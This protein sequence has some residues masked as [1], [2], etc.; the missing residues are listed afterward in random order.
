MPTSGFQPIGKPSRR[1]LDRQRFD[2][3]PLAKSL[4]IIDQKAIDAAR[5]NYCEHCGTMVGPFEVHHHESRGAGG[6]D[7]E[8]NLVNLCS[9]DFRVNCHDLAHRAIIP[10]E[11]I[12][13]I[14]E[15]RQSISK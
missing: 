6:D 14:I 1:R 11:T 10:R 7:V 3:L 2:G 8:G 4:R 15:R 13:S 9:G 12:A 5:K